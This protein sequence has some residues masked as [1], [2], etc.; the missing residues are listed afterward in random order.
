M[1]IADLKATIKD[2]NILESIE[3][4][5]LKNYL[6]KY[7]W[8]VSED[9]IR[10][11]QTVGTVYTKYSNELHRH[12]YVTHLFSMEWRDYASRMAENLYEIECLGISQL[13]T[14]CEITG[15][16]ILIMPDADLAEIDAMVKGI[17][18]NVVS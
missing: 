16:T 9:C 2:K 4:D 14:Y 15:N 10:D 18:N 12:L 1:D 8:D 17:V 11:G 7:E 5:M 6:E 3:P 13:K